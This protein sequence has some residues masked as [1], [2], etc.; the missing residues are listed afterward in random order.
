MAA[1]ALP[2]PP[3][4]SPMLDASGKLTATWARWFRQVWDYVR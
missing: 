3:V 2:P 4:E 1:P